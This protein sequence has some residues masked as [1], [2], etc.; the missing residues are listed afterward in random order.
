VNLPLTLWR[1]DPPS[2][3]TAPRVLA[4]LVR[5][6]GR[7]RARHGAHTQL[8]SGGISRTSRTRGCFD[9]RAFCHSLAKAGAQHSVTGKCRLRRGDTPVCN[10]AAGA[11]PNIAQF[12]RFDDQSGRPL[13]GHVR[14][15]ERSS[16]GSECGVRETPHWMQFAVVHQSASGA[17][18]MSS[19]QE[20]S[21][22]SQ[23][24]MSALYEADISQ[25]P[26]NAGY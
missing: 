15:L 18:R 8:L 13:Y 14:T 21:S 24:L 1:L 6:A 5:W 4:I 12:Q 16:R 11:L 3:A 9:I 22:R 23:E 2:N 10:F 25:P 17:K 19:S 7:L 20:S 26:R